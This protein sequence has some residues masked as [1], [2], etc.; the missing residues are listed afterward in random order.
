M[1]IRAKITAHNGVLII[2]CTEKN[3][4]PGETHLSIDQKG[5]IGQVIM[6]TRETLGVS[7]EALAL[8][9]T[10]KR[11]ADSLGDVDWWK[12]ND[13]HTAF[14]WLGPMCRLMDPS[15]AEASRQYIIGEYVSIPNEPPQEAVDAIDGEG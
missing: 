10:V 12:T 1:T 3:S 14:S 11:G 5:V 13:G 15:D 6:K 7:D 9:K 4:T 8:L 2:E